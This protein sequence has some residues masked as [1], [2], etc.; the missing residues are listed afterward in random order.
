MDISL[1]DKSVDDKLR[2]IEKTQL[3]VESD[4]ISID[5]DNNYIQIYSDNQHLTHELKNL[6]S[7]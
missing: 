1:Y 2:N 7:E 3:E 5:I 4:E 6:K